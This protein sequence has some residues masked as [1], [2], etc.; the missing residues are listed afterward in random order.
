[1]ADYFT[2]FSCLLDVGTN[3]NAVR[4][5]ELYSAL[6]DEDD[7]EPVLSDGFLLSVQPEHGGTE[8]WIRDDVSG[9]PKRVIRFVKLCGKEVWPDRALGGLPP[10]C[11]RGCL[12]YFS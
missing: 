3:E 2:H 11:E 5:L 8:L 6:S 4:A 10:S 1:M 9:D 12:S 7:D